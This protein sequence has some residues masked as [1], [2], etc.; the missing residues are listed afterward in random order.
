VCPGTVREGVGMSKAIT[1]DIRCK[2][3]TIYIVWKVLITG[4]DASLKLAKDVRRQFYKSFNNG[5]SFFK[6]GD[7]V[8]KFIMKAKYRRNGTWFPSDFK[9]P[10]RDLILIE[11][12]RANGGGASVPGGATLIHPRADNNELEPWKAENELGHGLGLLDRGKGKRGE[13]NFDGIKPYHIARIFYAQASKAQLDQLK[14]CCGTSIDE[15][16]T[17]PG[18]HIEVVKSEIKKPA[19]K[20]KMKKGK[21]ID[22]D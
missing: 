10:S 11:G 6:I 16:I 7:C 5:G 19:S 8:V 9:N 17:P 22:V 3:K 2:E 18:I 1:V 21:T 4:G 12:R 20:K 13:W 15:A 14:K